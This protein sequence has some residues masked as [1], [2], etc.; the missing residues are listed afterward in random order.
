MLHLTLFR[1]VT[2]YNLL[3]KFIRVATSILKDNMAYI[4]LEN[5]NSCFAAHEYD[6]QAL[7]YSFEMGW[8][9]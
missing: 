7:E 9:I 6:S 3:Q 8:D 2:Y 5:D 1:N 4:R